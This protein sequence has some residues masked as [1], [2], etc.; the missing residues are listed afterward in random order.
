M[1]K[2]KK[3]DEISSVGGGITQFKMSCDIN[4]D[5]DKVYDAVWWVSG[6]AD[7]LI[8]EMQVHHYDTGIF[9]R[10]LDVQNKA[11]QLASEA[12]RM[13]WEKKRKFGEQW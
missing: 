2:K 3:K 9:V 12:Q 11:N 4:W 1:T 8:K 6:M 13:M 10:A 7:F 5:I